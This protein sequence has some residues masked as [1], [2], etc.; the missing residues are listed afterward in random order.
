MQDEFSTY[1][2]LHQDDDVS[3]GCTSQIFCKHNH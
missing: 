2:D 3:I 1:A